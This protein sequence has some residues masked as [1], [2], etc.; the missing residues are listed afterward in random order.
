[1]HI[2]ARMASSAPQGVRRPTNLSLP[3]SLIEDA[4][5]LGINLSRACEQGIVAAVKAERERRWKDQN[6]EAVDDYN[7]WVETN[8]LPLAEYRQF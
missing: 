4:R 2:V 5:Q 1:M 8:G 6:R 3:V 7:R